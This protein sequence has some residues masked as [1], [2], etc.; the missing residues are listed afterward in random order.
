MARWP[1]LLVALAVLTVGA[2][3]IRWPP[4]S[5]GPREEEARAIV[6]NALEAEGPPPIVRWEAEPF[7]VPDQ[8][9]CAE[10]DYHPEQHM[11]RVVWRGSYSGSPAYIHELVHAWLWVTFG[12]ADSPHVRPEWARQEDIR[13]LL[14][15]AGL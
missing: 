9:C 11:A 5:G 15:A 14:V 4:V 8:G 1:W 3:A 7:W 10:G 2:C 6:W 13:A 12:D